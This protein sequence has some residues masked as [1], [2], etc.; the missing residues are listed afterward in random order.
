M[1]LYHPLDG[2]ANLKYKLQ[3]FLSS[4]KKNSKRKALTFNW[5][6]CCHLVICLWLIFFHYLLKNIV[7]LSDELIIFY[8]TVSELV[9]F[10][11]LSNPLELCSDLFPR[12]LCR[13]VGISKDQTVWLDG[14]RPPPRYVFKNNE[15]DKLKNL[16]NL[17]HLFYLM[18]DC[19][20]R[21]K[22]FTRKCVYLGSLH[23]H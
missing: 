2:V 15:F 20:F 6:R 11:S 18:Q 8:L 3:Y 22:T 1:G 7:F 16:S 13:P 23:K 4:N 17:D 5:D 21:R 9:K 14:A 10:L 12:R 19:P